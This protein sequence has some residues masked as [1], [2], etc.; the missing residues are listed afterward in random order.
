MLFLPP[1]GGGGRQSQ[2]NSGFFYILVYF[3]S[4]VVMVEAGKIAETAVGDDDVGMEADDVEEDT[5]NILPHVNAGGVL[6]IMNKE[7]FTG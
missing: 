3:F 2:Y 4:E 7:G 5:E 6:G 1:P